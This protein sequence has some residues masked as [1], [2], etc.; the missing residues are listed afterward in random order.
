MNKSNYLKNTEIELC[1][2]TDSISFGKV[3]HIVFDHDGTI[4]TLRK[5][6]E[7][8]MRKVMINEIIGGGS[9]GRFAEPCQHLYHTWH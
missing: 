8:I 6:W 1:H 4:S 7:I 3:K 9:S 2:K 5:G